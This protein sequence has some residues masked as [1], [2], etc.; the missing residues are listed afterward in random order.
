MDDN[1][2]NLIPLEIILEQMGF[3]CD[4]ANGGQEAI[5]MFIADRNKTCCRVKYQI[6]L[7]DLNM[8]VVDGFQATQRILSHQ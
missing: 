1:A 5:D 2:L 7:M 3:I 6:V 8:P 4:T